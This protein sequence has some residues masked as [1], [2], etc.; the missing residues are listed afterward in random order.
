MINLLIHGHTGKLGKKIIFNINQN[1]DQNINYLGNIDIRKEDFNKSILDTI[2]LVIV[3]VTIDIA[4]KN[5]LE[6]LISN[7]IYVPLI[8]GTTGNLPIDLIET[9]STF[10][11]VAQISNFSEGITSILNILPII[12]MNVPSAKI[13]IFETHHIHKKDGPS[14]TAKTLADKINLPYSNIFYSRE[15]EIYGIHE[16]KYETS[17]EI[18]TIKHEVKDHNIFAIGCLKWVEKISKE[19]NG[20]YKN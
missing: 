18:I 7:K 13:Q 3:D 2:N 16:V 20:Y 19:K 10:V 1:K 14:G 11:P 5:L 4:C 9:Y 12:N 17:S 6:Y 8:I 15:G